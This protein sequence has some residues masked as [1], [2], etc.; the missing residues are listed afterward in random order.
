M[1]NHIG[2]II[3]E[4]LDV[5]K[6]R[7]KLVIAEIEHNTGRKLE[8]QKIAEDIGVTPQQF[9]AWVNNR[10]WPRMDKA[11][12]LAKYLGVRVD[13]LYQYVEGTNDA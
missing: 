12:K 13:D 7:I 4:E 11:F 8:H 3:A 9:S 6:P 5:L 10:G 2:T 1:V